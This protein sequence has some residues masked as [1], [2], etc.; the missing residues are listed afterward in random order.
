M[1]GFLSRLFKIFQTEANDAINKLEN[2][3]K[4]TEQGIRDLKKDLDAALRSLAEVKS[5]TIRTRKEFAAHQ[6]GERDW[7]AKAVALIGKA[8]SGELEPNEA[9][10]L[11]SEAL[12][13]RDT[14]KKRAQETQKVLKN[15]E[16]MTKKIEENIRK[17]KQQISEWESELNSLK[18]RS[19]VSKVSAKVNRQLAGVDSSDTIAN[20]N[21]MKEKIEEQEALAESYEEMADINNDTGVDDEINKALGASSSESLKELKSRMKSNPQIE[22]G[23][24]S[25][26]SNESDSLKD[27]K[28]KLKGNS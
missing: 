24:T 21:R 12:K 20:L 28:A 15:Y 23:N 9:D 26:H 25:A 17:L 5:I 7:E 22:G 6:K 3:V 2:P 27:L 4:M 19:K 8:E 1:F 14:Y 13:K 18:A 10:R 16:A 11:A